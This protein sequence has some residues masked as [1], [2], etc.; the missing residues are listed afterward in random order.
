V[1][2]W[3]VYMMVMK[4]HVRLSST[5]IC[6]TSKLYFVAFFLNRHGLV[7]VDPLKGTSTSKRAL[8]VGPPGTT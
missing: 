5:A 2:V 8:E 6:S 3:D 7:G 1:L 4:R